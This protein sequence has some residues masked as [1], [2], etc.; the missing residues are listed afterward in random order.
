MF[1]R[2]GALAAVAALAA[3]SGPFVLDE[4]GDPPSPTT[5]PAA[6][7]GSSPSK[8]TPQ[9]ADSLAAD[10]TADLEAVIQRHPDSQIAIALTAVGSHE[11]ARV[12]GEAPAIVA[13]STIKVP[14]SLAA[15]REDGADKA[16]PDVTDA[17]TISDNAAAQRLW[18]SL[19]TGSQAAAAVE[20]QLGRGGDERT[21][22]PTEVSVP[23]YS[24]FGQTTWRLRDQAAFTAS[25]PCLTGSATVVDAMGRV[26][27]GQ[28]WGLGGFDGAR[29]KGGW[30]PTPQGYVVRQ[31]G[32]LPGAKGATAAAV[33]VRT[34]THDEGTAIL[35]EVAGVLGEH[36]E[37]LPVGSCG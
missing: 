6:S 5:S 8:T 11:R 33:Q 24:A 30:G 7:P 15:V 14:L 3:C 17:L 18:E 32:I 26:A 4:G 31:L 1:R 23:G 37:H 12:V 13:W 36:A 34:G 19:G 16:A 25:L 27:Q 9:Q 20:T 10:L 2:I 35:D 28:S 29:F 21:T 22:V